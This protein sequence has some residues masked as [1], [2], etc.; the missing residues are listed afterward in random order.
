MRR[1]DFSDLKIDIQTEKKQSFE[2]EQSIAGNAPF[3]RGIYTSMFIQ[4]PLKC[5]MV[6]DHNSPLKSNE[7]I[8]INLKK[9]YQDFI[10]KFTSK[11]SSNGIKVNSVDDMCIL[12]NDLPLNNISFTLNLDT[13]L[14]IPLIAIF[15]ATSEELGFNNKQI[16]FS[17]QHCIKNSIKKNNLTDTLFYLNKHVSQFETIL[18]STTFSEKNINFENTLA[19][20][21]SNISNY[22]EVC[23]SKGLKI[24]NIAPKFSLSIELNGSP[25]NTIAQLRA[26]RIVWSKLIKQYSPKLEESQALKIHIT[27]SNSYLNTLSAVLGGAQSCI[28]SK[29][30]FNLIEKETFITK[31]VDPFGGSNIIE[32]FTKKSAN[33]IWNL[34]TEIKNNNFKKEFNQNKTVKP[35]LESKNILELSI[36]AAKKRIK[37]GEIFNIIEDIE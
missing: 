24:D 16:N 12:L 35:Q 20:L 28:T 22:I 21:I 37:L 25:S 15:L 17:I 34:I 36:D 19:K 1:K 27:N 18:F 32:E 14:N 7:I 9:G 33:K 29:E 23:L 31:T 30:N 8:K 11:N 3:L 13:T 6:I 10:L 5:K 26:L 4:K 2:Y